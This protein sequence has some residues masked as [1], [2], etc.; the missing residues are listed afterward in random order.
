MW[1]GYSQCTTTCG[2]GKQSRSRACDNPFPR[3]NGLFCQ[4]DGPD[5]QIAALV[6]AEH[7]VCANNV[8][9]PSKLLTL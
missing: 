8:S 5:N 4:V 6:E 2:D 7:R 1:S 3:G 9:C